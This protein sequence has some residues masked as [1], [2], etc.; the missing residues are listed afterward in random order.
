M[1]YTLILIL[2]STSLVLLIFLNIAVIIYG[3]NIKRS[4]EIIG[5]GQEIV[6]PT[7]LK[8]QLNNLTVGI[9]ELTKGME[10]RLQE[11]KKHTNEAENLNKSSMGHIKEAKETFL[12]F[13]KIRTQLE[14]EINHYKEG[15]ENKQ[16]HKFLRKFIEFR[17]YM[18]EEVIKSE[19]NEQTIEVVR[20]LLEYYDY[21]L[22]DYDVETD[23]PIIGKNYND[24]DFLDETPLI[25]NTIDPN[26]DYEIKEI[27]TPAFFLKGI[28]GQKN[29]ISKS[30]VRILKFKGDSN[31][32]NNRD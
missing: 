13:E 8:K 23:Q 15:A 5:T 28:G 17:N 10:K 16:V 27:I 14:S 25:E 7:V 20:G 29:Y 12:L 31:G 32:K 1:D 4:K 11:E 9:N 26:R 22:K 19:N 30:K 2:L 3:E 6:L 18:Q 24:Y 21:A